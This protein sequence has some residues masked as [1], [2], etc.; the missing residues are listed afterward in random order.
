MKFSLQKLFFGIKIEW[1]VF[2]I[3]FLLSNLRFIALLSIAVICVLNS[4][5]NVAYL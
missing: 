4:H 3:V 1:P 5:H 2:G